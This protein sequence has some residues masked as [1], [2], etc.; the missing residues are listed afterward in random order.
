MSLSVPTLLAVGVGGALGSIA[1]YLLAVLVAR[2]GVLPWT[3]LGINIAGSLL[4]GFLVR[5]AAAAVQGT[6]PAA[7]VGATVGFCGGFTT[8]SAFSFELLSLVERGAWA[9]AAAYALAS[10]MLCLGAALLGATLARALRA[11]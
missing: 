5:Y 1:R 7:L 6:P 4:L 9:R 2:P 8:F 10:V 3:T 11:P